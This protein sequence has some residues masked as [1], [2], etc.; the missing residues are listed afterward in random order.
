MSSA[1]LSGSELRKLGTEQ[2]REAH[3]I[4]Q[5]Q[6]AASKEFGHVSQYWLPQCLTFDQGRQKLAEQQ[7]QIEDFREPLEGWEPVVNDTGVFVFRNKGNGRDYVPTDHA[8][9]LMCQVGRGMSEWAAR[10]MR[11]PIRHATKLG[12]DGEKEVL[13]ER[14]KADAE[15][16]RDYVKL[17]LFNQERTDQKKI[18]LFRT[19]KDGT[20]RALLSEQYA[21]V[22]N[23][24]YLDLLVKLIPGGMLSHW[25]GDA[26]SIY[27]NILIPDTIRTEKDSDYGGMLSVGNSEIGLRRIS[28]MPSVFRAICM[29][30]CIWEQE[31]GVE[32]DIRHRGQIDFEALAAKIKENLEAQIPL[33]PQ[34]IER[35]LGLRAYGVGDATLPNLFAQLSIDFSVTKKEVVGVHQAFLKEV[36]DL[37]ADEGKTAFGVMNAVTRFGQTLEDGRWVRFD[38]IAGEIANMKRD[39]W[40]RF[41]NRASNLSEKQVEKRIGELAV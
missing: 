26:D 30:G 16:L 38:Q 19:W 7:A 25:K 4:I 36:S 5:S 27:G 14:G 35:V 11:E 32:V 10:A 40:T 28:S 8:L 15:L 37:G 12:D 6:G 3:A 22:N 29:N 31:K 17:H 1:N 41:C 2:G 24:W 21:I 23:G 13:F 20:L 39:D 9:K 18:R 34:G 33:L